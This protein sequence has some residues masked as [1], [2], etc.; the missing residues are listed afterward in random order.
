MDHTMSLFGNLH[1]NECDSFLCVSERVPKH[2][3][4]IMN[5]PPPTMEQVPQSCLQPHLWEEQDKQE[6][7]GHA[8][9]R[10]NDNLT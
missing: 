10:H 3:T 4:S 5:L 9:S 8:T 7:P 1:K 2:P 6:P